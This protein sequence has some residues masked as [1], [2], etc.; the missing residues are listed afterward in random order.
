MDEQQEEQDWLATV[1]LTGNVEESQPP[2]EDEAPDSAEEAPP[3][4]QEAPAAPQPAP[5]APPAPPPPPPEDPRIQQL[6]EELDRAMGEKANL[7]KRLHDTQAA[8]TRSRQEAKQN[9]P[10]AKQPEED[11]GGWFDEDEPQSEPQQQPAGQEAPPASQERDSELNARMDK[12]E[13]NQQQLKQ[14]MEAEKAAE[15]WAAKEAP[16]RQ[17]HSDYAEIV[18][19]ELVPALN[20]RD[21]RAQFLMEEFQRRGSTPEAAYQVGLLLRRMNGGTAGTEQPMD[22]SPARESR[23]DAPDWNSAPPGSG[24][25]GFDSERSPLDEVLSEMRR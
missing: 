1:G 14:Q 17:Q 10:P 16:V 9:P 22:S 6:R 20:V 12:I 5:E 15:A 7:E 25:D 24:N 11:G 21:A 8:L 18:D 4:Q 23:M 2:E 19:K 3:Q 13:A